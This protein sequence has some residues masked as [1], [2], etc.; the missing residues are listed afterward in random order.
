[1]KTSYKFFII[2]ISLF[3]T[4]SAPLFSQNNSQQISK[5]QNVKQ[6]TLENGL[7]VFFLENSSDAL[8]HIKI[9]FKAGFSNQTKENNGFFKLFTK[10]IQ[11]SNPHIPFSSAE[12]LS[13]FSSYSLEITN[14]QLPKTLSSLSRSFFEPVFSQ[15]KIQNELT[16][17]KNEVNKNAKELSTLINSS[18]DSRVFSEEPWKHDSGIYPSLFSKN[19]VDSARTILTQIAERYYTPQNCA[20]YITGNFDSQKTILELSQ[21]FGRYYSNFKTPVSKPTSALNKQR[22]YVFHHPEISEELTQIVVQYTLMSFEECELSAALLNNN[23]SSFKNKILAQADLNIPGWEYID[24]KAAHKKDTSRLIIQ[25]LMQKPEKNF[26]KKKSSFDQ[27]QLFLQNIEKLSSFINEN[28]LINAKLNLQEQTQNIIKNPLDYMEKLSEFWAISPFFKTGENFMP[29]DILLEKQETINQIEIQNLK[30]FIDSESPFIFV[31]INSKDYKTNKKVFFQAGFEE[32]NDKNASW[33]MQELTKETKNQYQIDDDKYFSKN[34]Q[35]TND[36]DYYNQ[37]ISQIQITTLSNGIKV[38]SKKNITEF[39]T[40]ITL[41][42]NGGQLNSSQN[43]GFEEVMC[44]IL[45][46][47]I[48]TELNKQTAN[49]IILNNTKVTHQTDLSTS[50][51]FIEFNKEDSFAVCN[52]IQKAIIFTEIPPAAADKAVFSRQYKK[53]LENGSSAKQME[54]SVIKSLYG[55]NAFYNIFETQNEILQDTNYFSILQAYPDFL[56]AKRYNIILCGDFDQNIF[57]YLDNAFSYFSNSN[58]QLN[59]CNDLPNF[60]KNKTIKVKINH[61]FLTD[62]PAELA[63][64]QPAVLVPTTEFKD[65]VIFAI[66]VQQPQDSKEA[67]IFNAVLNSFQKEF[68]AILNQNEKTKENTVSIRLP[69]TKMPFA[70]ITILDVNAPKEV[71]SSYKTAR[72]QFI[73]KITSSSAGSFIQQIK[74]DWILSQMKET[75]TNYGTSKL[76]QKGIENF[77]ENPKADFY[78]QEYN[79]IQNATIQDFISAT[80]SLPLTPPLRAYGK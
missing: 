45:S 68:Q 63:G 55:Q 44:S 47:L 59:T 49:G 3:I 33:Y 46:S 75:A 8:V 12:C 4:L 2:L 11:T 37:N 1:M 38:F 29:A 25:T 17:M 28:E 42:I 70:L 20:I 57:D 69:K 71:D 30:N 14:E 56:D 67:A 48:Q 50:S 31:M 21:T 22:K 51:I 43:N 10:I 77:P 60:Q 62:I 65:P 79:S 19:T 16:K 23:Y 9:V 15:E 13:D 41:S 80:E 18:I 24:V 58:V 32:I 78:L 39:S 72:N 7:Q 40:V 34:Q 66:Q 54:S 36:N 5:Q 76:I 27:I 74:N 73:K 61:T 64:P 53:R 26:P 52:A 6:V 35:N